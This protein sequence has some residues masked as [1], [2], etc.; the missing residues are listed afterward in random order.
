M[1]MADLIARIRRAPHGAFS[2]TT[3]ELEETDMPNP[4]HFTSHQPVIDDI[5]ARILTIRD[6]L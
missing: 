4:M 2:A 3:H 1:H 6:S 5:E